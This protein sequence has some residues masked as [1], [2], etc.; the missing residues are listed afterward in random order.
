MFK[1]VLSLF[2]AILLFNGEIAYAQAL[3]GIEVFNINDE[4]IEKVMPIDYEVQ[5]LVENYIYGIE[6]IYA[7]FNPIPKNGFAVKVP[8]APSVKADVTG[9]ILIID[10]IIIMFPENDMPFLLIFEDDDKLSCYN[11]KGD[12]EVLLESLEYEPSGRYNIY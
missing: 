8:L 6:G 5:K 10:Q 9:K 2:F 7:K 1:K 12:T 4:I 3:G 11:F